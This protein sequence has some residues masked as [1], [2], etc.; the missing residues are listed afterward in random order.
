MQTAAPPGGAGRGGAGAASDGGSATGGGAGAS[1]S[2][3]LMRMRA[4]VVTLLSM[5]RSNNIGVLLANLKMPPAQVG[6]DHRVGGHKADL[7]GIMC[8]MGMMVHI[9]PLETQSNSQES[10]LAPSGV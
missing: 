3:S 8:G 4:P 1:S 2:G 10:R 7:T 6:S 9:F 5:Q